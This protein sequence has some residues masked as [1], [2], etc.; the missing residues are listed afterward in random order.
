MKKVIVIGSGISGMTC[1]CALANK[2]YKVDIFEK[3]HAPGGYCQSFTRK[4]FQFGAAV[5][6]VGGDYGK[7][8]VNCIL[9]S[10]GVRQLPEWY[11]FKERVLVGDRSISMCNSN[12]AETLKVLF[13]E[14]AESIQRFWEEIMKI[15]NLLN[16][17]DKGANSGIEKFSVHD[18]KILKKCRKISTDEFLDSFFDNEEIKGILAAVSDAMPGSSVFAFVRMVAFANCSEWTY[19]PAGGANAII[20]VLVDRIRELGGEIHLESPVDKIIMKEGKAQGVISKGVEYHADYIV[21]NCDMN[22]TLY[23][24]IGEEYL[25]PRLVRK[26]KEKFVESPSCFSVWLGLDTDV[27]T[28]GYEPGNMTYYPNKKS[29]LKDK[30]ELISSGSVQRDD[31]F[32]LIS[33]SANNDP[34]ACPEG[35][36]QVMLGM[37]CSWDFENLVELRKTDIHTYRKKKR[38]V[39]QK[40]IE[41]AEKFY[42]NL[43][44]H[45][46][47]M[48]IATPATYERYTG[49][50]KGAY[51]GYKCTPGLVENFSVIDGKQLVGNLF[52][53]GHWGGVGDGVIF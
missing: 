13:P 1:A 53:T 33:L 26:V 28:L 9:R 43:H 16:I 8:N 34:E 14:E 18:L 6:R 11:S 40:L 31:D 46:D 49:N 12:V 32:L 15:D 5:H 35:K 27:K 7:E 2:G 23:K 29:V 45:I 36:G 47:V 22:T 52:T 41:K 20:D 37:M 39:A 10:V 50:S 24:L 19:Q 44:E 25:N 21:S 38:Q 48:E 3:H 42:P 51:G 17:I 4:G 30:T